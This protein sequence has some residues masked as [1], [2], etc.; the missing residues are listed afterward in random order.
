MSQGQTAKQRASST[1]GG[2]RDV[3]C[4]FFQSH[5]SFEINCEGYVDDAACT[6]KY[7]RIAD[8][9]QQFRLYCQE[10]Y[11]YCEHYTALMLVK[12]DGTEE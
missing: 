6:M 3:L 7:K 2:A 12:Y 11:K 9:K 5:S 4:P 10:N 8:K 1:N